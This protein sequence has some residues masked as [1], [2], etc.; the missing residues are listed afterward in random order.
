MRPRRGIPLADAV[1]LGRASRRTLVIR[2]VLGAGLV[3]A[4]V[5]AYLVAHRTRKAEPVLPTGTS[6]VI[7]IDMSWSVSYDNY[8]EIDRT[9]RDLASSGRRVGLVLFSDVAYEAL[10]PGTPATELRSYL[11]FFARRG[12]VSPWR[13]AFSGGTRIWTGLDL[14]RRILDRDRVANGSVVLISDLADAPNDRSRLAQT[15]VAFARDHIPIRIVGLDPGRDDEHFFR[16]ALAHGGGTVTTLRS[17]PGAAPLRKTS[18]AFPT[19]LVALA[20][21]L[22]LLLGL[23]ERTLDRLEWTGRRPA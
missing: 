16:N 13:D 18:P 12:V 6:P 3:G 8:R 22:A 2:L 4:L 19:A 1:A 11:R 7:A 20:A 23:N 21:T 14:A 10:P 17:S 9:L 5:A 15:L